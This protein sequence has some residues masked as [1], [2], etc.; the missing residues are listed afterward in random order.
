MTIRSVTLQMRVY[1][2]LVTITKLCIL[3]QLYILTHSFTIYHYNRAI[4]WYCM[5]AQEK[6]SNFVSDVSYIAL[7]IQVMRN[8][9]NKPL[10][11]AAHL[12]CL[13][14]LKSCMHVITACIHVYI[15][16]KAIRKSC[17][18]LIRTYMQK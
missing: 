11:W 17:C 3:K 10:P 7:Y 9:V 6:T 5:H 12:P 14:S 16:Q 4:L 2:K 13:I 15:D 8:Y 18:A 1:Y